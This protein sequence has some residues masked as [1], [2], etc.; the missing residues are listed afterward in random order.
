MAGHLEQGTTV[1][2][3]AIVTVGVMNDAGL[4]RIDDKNYR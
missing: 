1:F 2:T 3:F 4:S